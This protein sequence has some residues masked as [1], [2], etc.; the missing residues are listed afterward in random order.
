[1]NIMPIKMQT[2]DKQFAA[3]RQLVFLALLCL[4]SSTGC[5]CFGI[6]PAMPMPEPPSQPP[7]HTRTAVKSPNLDWSRIRKVVVV[8]VMNQVVTLRGQNEVAQRIASSIRGLVKTGSAPLDVSLIDPQECP[9]RPAKGVYDEMQM[10]QIARNHQADAVL[11]CSMMSYS[12]YDPMVGELAIAMVDSAESVVLLKAHSRFELTDPGT[13]KDYEAFT[14]RQTEDEFD[15]KTQLMS[16]E[17]FLDYVVDRTM[18]PLKE[19]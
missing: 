6:G 8:P 11:F 3:H 2:N 10:A 12:P 18:T 15:A 17:N 14:K 1:M 19:I 13:N 9:L 4:V 7:P 5:C 16:P